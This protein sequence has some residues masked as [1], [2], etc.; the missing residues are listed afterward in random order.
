MRPVI[1]LINEYVML[2]YVPKRNYNHSVKIIPQSVASPA[3]WA[4]P[5]IRRC[6]CGTQRSRSILTRVASV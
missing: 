3:E 1:S 4:G 2:C 6:R 5:W